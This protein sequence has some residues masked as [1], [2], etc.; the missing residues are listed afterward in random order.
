MV[1]TPKYVAP[2]YV[3]TGECD[4]RGDIFALG[5]I[6]FEMIAGS[7]PFK[8]QTRRSLIEER[9]V[10]KGAELHRLAPHCSHGFIRVVE[11]AMSVGVKSRY[12][13]ATELRIDL[14]RVMAGGESGV[15]FQLA[16][17]GKKIE[18]PSA[19]VV[20]PEPAVC[21]ERPPRPQV[22]SGGFKRPL[23]VGAVGGAVA[24]ATAVIVV[25]GAFVLPK[26]DPR[27]ATVPEGVYTGVVRGLLVSEEPLSLDVWRTEAGLFALVGVEGCKVAK[28]DDMGRFGCGGIRFTLA[29][30][31]FEQGGGHGSLTEEGWGISA[32]FHLVPR[33]E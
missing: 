11:K 12:Q 9:F 20:K 21:P 32:P 13:S 5:V 27:I 33:G 28:A 10:P 19:K 3:E 2:E 22:W 1:G 16:P 15:E 18:R 24:V 29:F 17:K 26:R 31:R 30:D 25:A 4:H 23:L 8:A 7:S 14:E 6:A